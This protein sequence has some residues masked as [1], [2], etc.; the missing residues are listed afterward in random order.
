MGCCSSQTG[1]ISEPGLAPISV[2]E[3]A[4]KNTSDGMVS[5]SVSVELGAV[6]E[7]QVLPETELS[8]HLI[9]AGLGSN[10]GG[11]SEVAAS[12]EETTG[13]QLVMDT[14]HGET[15]VPVLTSVVEAEADNTRVVDVLRQSGT[16]Q[17]NAY[18]L[19]PPVRSPSEQAVRSTE[20]SPATSVAWAAPWLDSVGK[21]LPTAMLSS[22][23]ASI[24]PTELPA[25][26]SRP[27]WVRGLLQSSVVTS[28]APPVMTSASGSNIPDPPSLV[29]K[30]MSSYAWYRGRGEPV[31]LHLYDVSEGTVTWMNNLIRPHGS[32][33]FHAAVEVFGQEWSFGFADSGTTGVYSCPPRC[34]QRHKYRESIAMG[35]TPMSEIR[36]NDLIE[37]MSEEW[38][39]CSY[40]LLGKNCCHFCCDLCKGLGVGPAPE[41]V[42]SLAGAGATIVGRVGQVVERAH[43]EAGIAA[44]KVA[45]Y[46]GAAAE[47]AASKADELDS[48]YKITRFLSQDIDEEYLVKS[49]QSLWAKA[50]GSVA[51]DTQGQHSSATN[52]REGHQ[53]LSP[54]GHMSLPLSS[55]LKSSV[56]L[57]TAEDYCLPNGLEAQINRTGKPLLERASSTRARPSENAP[58]QGV[59]PCDGLDDRTSSA[60]PDIDLA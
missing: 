27:R 25:A 32:G 46:A 5:D 58:G 41:Y 30:E 7:P 40:D 19:P 9:G 47:V 14:R 50:V 33:V 37:S 45:E 29:I 16:E 34:N 8:G 51:H 42:T 60:A 59:V 13:D 17:T 21:L 57:A 54:G 4:P 55:P 2:E 31:W 49:A 56:P 36:V 35:W 43:A 6:S 23:V 52:N 15:I 28:H 18:M 11:I 3:Q 53:L 24:A 39:A 44:V 38:P 20:S 10:A 12:A 26:V 1:S 22:T 48:H